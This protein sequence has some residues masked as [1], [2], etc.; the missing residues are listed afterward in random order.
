[1]LISDNTQTNCE[2]WKMLENESN[3]IW[4]RMY[5]IFNGNE[6]FLLSFKVGQIGKQVLQLN[7]YETAP[8]FL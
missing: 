8:Y 5:E 3:Q 2:C 6:I 1:L 4:D 7:E